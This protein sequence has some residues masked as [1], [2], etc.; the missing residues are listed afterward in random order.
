M[1]KAVSII[2]CLCM[3]ASGMAAAAADEYIKTPAG[4]TAWENSYWQRKTTTAVTD[5]EN[6]IELS[7]EPEVVKSGKGA[8]KMYLEKTASGLESVLAQN[9]SGIENG[10]YYRLSG[11]IFYA[12][13]GNTTPKAYFRIWMGK[14]RIAFLADVATA[15]QWS[16]LNLVFRYG[17]D[18]QG[19]PD[20][21][22]DP[23]FI[24]KV[25]GMGY[26]YADNLSLKEVSLNETTSEYEDAQGASEL[27]RNG[28]FELDL[29]APADVSGL[30]A[31]AGNSDITVSWDDIT[32][33][34]TEKVKIFINDTLEAAVDSNASS[35]YIDSLENGTEYTICV[36]TVSKGGIESDGVTVTS[37][38]HPP[39]VML[40]VIKD[41]VKN[42]IIG[43][44]EEMEYSL[45]G[46][47]WL[48][49]DP[50]N[51][52]VLEGDVTVSVRVHSVY[53]GVYAPSQVLYFTK[54]EAANDDM[55]IEHISLRENSFELTGKLKVPSEKRITLLAAKKGLDKRSYDNIL[56]I[57]Q[58]KSTADGRFGF[59]LPVA[60]ERKGNVNDGHYT[61]YLETDDGI[62]LEYNEVI[63]VCKNNRNIGIANLLGSDDP[64][65]LIC[66]DAGDV[67]TA[68]GINTD[69][70]KNYSSDATSA[71]LVSALSQISPTDEDAS[72]KIVSAANETLLIT[73]TKASDAEKMFYLLSNYGSS[74][75]LSYNGVSVQSLIDDGGAEIN[76]AAAYMAGKENKTADE[77]VKSYRA[78]CALYHINNATYGE[79]TKLIEDNSCY[80]DIDSD[81][82]SDYLD[83]KG[84]DADVAAKALVRYKNK[85]SFASA[86]DIAEGLKAAVNTVKTTEKPKI[87]TGGTGGGGGGGGGS[88]GYITSVAS[89]FPYV[90]NDS[91]SK[92]DAQ[93]FN[94]LSGYSWAEESILELYGKGV[95]KGYGYGLFKPSGN[96]TREE[97]VKM[98]VVAFGL[99]DNSA[100]CDFGDVGSE[101]WFY[102]YVA[103]AVKNGIVNGISEH[104]F[105]TGRPITRKDIAVMTA[106]CLEKAGILFP[107]DDIKAFADED[108]ISSYA[109]EAVYNMKKL[110]VISGYEDGTFLPENNATRA[111]ACKICCLAMRIKVGK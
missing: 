94:D 52:P 51:P 62:G 33:E 79:I 24:I 61:V 45:D 31:E 28:G 37:I 40:N 92:K 3:S 11:D 19:N 2:L 18:E 38:P 80:F 57:G 66:G 8:V 63:F 84:D 67:F 14:K 39:F 96:V 43:I 76:S 74:A 54:N 34:L 35:Y 73:A 29:Q 22:Y 85:T 106:R 58:V 108:R 101:D 82:L 68:I 1:K 23:E 13:T 32:D 60:N 7:Q 107:G 12:H 46:G 9:I 30:S 104:E 5:G 110:G 91:D 59:S 17:Y 20:D 75:G 81:V 41:D 109:K 56:L 99:T 88:K 15:G 16:D 49:Y 97:Y 4:I 47:E 48:M 72:G 102:P 27:I 77:L 98:L 95:V 44:T 53:P 105:G 87:S 64:L 50:D 26:L 55:Q 89:G 69:D 6:G 25:S 90:E 93:P 86:D 111:E 103:A 83:I 78:G 10:K 65:S 70:F 36:K 100:A 42:R 21:S 71:F